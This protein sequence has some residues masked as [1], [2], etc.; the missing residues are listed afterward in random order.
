LAVFLTEQQTHF[1]LVPGLEIKRS[2]GISRGKDDKIDAKKIAKYA[3]E[4]RDELKTYEMPSEQINLLKRLLSLRVRLVK[5]R[6]GYKASLK[7]QK[8]ILI[9]KENKVLFESQEKIIKYLTKQIGTIEK[10][11]D[12]IINNNDSLKTIYKLIISIKSVGPQTALF[13]IVYTSAFKKFANWRKFASYVGTAP[14]PNSSG[15]SIRGKTKVS[16]LA[17]KKIKSLLDQCA[18]SA[19]QH[20]PEM[21]IFYKKRV[22]EGKNEMST[23]NIVRNK[24][25][26]RIFAVV[27]RGTHYVDIM[28]YAA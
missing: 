27:K 1:V 15:T 11:M 19:I 3:F 8:R 4:K 23:I 22:E 21:K 20:N 17:Y 9:K 25:L 7:E 2:L 18:K 24:I 10:E 14:F 13:L 26:A 12:D 5:Q 16:N 28:R 6:A